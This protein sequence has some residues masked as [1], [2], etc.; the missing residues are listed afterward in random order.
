MSGNP[1]RVLVIQCP[2][3][4]CVSWAGAGGIVLCFLAAANCSGR[5]G[6]GHVFVG[7]FHG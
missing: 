2:R 7:S 6:C 3:G 1:Q 4:Q 5:H